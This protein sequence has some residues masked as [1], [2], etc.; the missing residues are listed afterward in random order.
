MLH[1]YMSKQKIGQ[2]GEKMAK[3][4]L[5]KKGYQ[6]ITTNFK[7]RGGEI[8]LVCKKGNLIIFTEVKT[9]TT[10]TFGL[11]IESFNARKKK[12][13]RRAILRYLQIYNYDGSWQVDFVG[14]EI[15]RKLR[16]AKIKHYDG[17]ELR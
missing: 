10:K 14:I 7:V 2:I 9:R 1:E 8:D 11:P 3:D 16:T 15:D 5:I 4:L 6:I 17:M 12:R 13:F